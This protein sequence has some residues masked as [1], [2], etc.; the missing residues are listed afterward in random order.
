MKATRGGEGEIISFHEGLMGG[1]DGGCGLSAIVS[2]V[3]GTI[4]NY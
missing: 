4:R 1:G 3:E 2:V